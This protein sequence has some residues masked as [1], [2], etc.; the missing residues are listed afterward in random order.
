MRTYSDHTDSAIGAVLDEADEKAKATDILN[1][2]TKQFHEV[3]VL[4]CDGCK[5]KLAIEYLDLAKPN[6]SHHQGRH[7]VPISNRLGSFRMRLDG[8]MGYK[9]A[10][11][12]NTILSGMEEGI[13]PVAKRMNDG[14]VIIPEGGMELQP[15]HYGMVQERIKA[16]KYSPDI[17]VTAKDTI[18]E[19]FRVRR[20]K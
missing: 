2:Y 7:I 16:S 13:V 5:T 11:G 4:I 17:R 20:I 10:C 19:T 8:A 18:T 3:Y 15:H 6:P 9:C 12:N 1:Y 14:S